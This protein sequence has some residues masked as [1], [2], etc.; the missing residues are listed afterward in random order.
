MTDTKLRILDAAERLF[1]EYGYSATSLRHIIAE[2]QVN[3]AAIHYHFGSKQDLLDQVIL[4][5]AGPMNERRLKL[6]DQFE[7]EAGPGPA[8]VEKIMEA[9]IAPAIL[10]EKSPEFVKLM[11]RVHEEGLMPEIARRNFQPM[12]ARFLS[13][14]H[15][16][17][18]DMS[19]KE[20]A[21]KA[22][23]ALGAM[24]H[25]LTARPEIDSEAGREAPAIVA[26]RLVAFLS[27]GF[28]APAITEKEI[29]VRQ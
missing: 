27:S 10:I 20:L 17:L 21:W 3:L 28:R 24:A 26:R 7:T 29:E 19:A 12:I 18:P 11:G 16:A 22:H 13:A 25:T 9:F 2:A 8:G 4:R 23:F 1:G 6:L 14:L 5:K 15:R